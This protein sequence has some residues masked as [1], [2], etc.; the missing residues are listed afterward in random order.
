MI[1]VLGIGNADQHSGDIAFSVVLGLMKLAA[2]GDVDGALKITPNEV[3]PLQ[4][5]ELHRD[6]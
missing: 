5:G 1:G 6:R 3:P 4:P 2:Q